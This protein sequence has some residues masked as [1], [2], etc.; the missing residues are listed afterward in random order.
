MS[1]T[2]N[3]K[4]PSCNGRLDKANRAGSKYDCRDCGETVHEAVARAAAEGW[5]QS[6]ADGDDKSAEY[7]QRLLDTGGV[8]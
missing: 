3:Y 1:K 7:A 8:R 5:L 6:L 4:C 2:A